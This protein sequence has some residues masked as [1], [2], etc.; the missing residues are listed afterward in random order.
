MDKDLTLNANT[1]S[2][3]SA[4]ARIDMQLQSMERRTERLFGSRG[5]GGVFNK[6]LPELSGF[7]R[8]LEQQVGRSL[9]R[10]IN[11][12]ARFADVFAS[13][14]D[15]MLQVVTQLG[16]INPLLNGLFGAG[17][18]TIADVPAGQGL[19][20]GLFSGIGGLFGAAGT[21]R[22]LGGPVQAGRAYLVGEQGPEIFVPQ[23]SGGV[24]PMRQ[25]TSGSGPVINVSIAT[26][27]PQR[28]RESSGQISALLL[29]AV[30]RGQRLR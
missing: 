2:A 26:P 10:L 15:T 27:D 30:R 11:G 25:A 23:A 18:S 24:Q 5:Q 29:D 8:V 17:R 4:L 21:Q 12:G 1:R 7:S 6:A 3:E 22:A 28:F 16:I 9:D 19:L 13:V 20:S 14:R